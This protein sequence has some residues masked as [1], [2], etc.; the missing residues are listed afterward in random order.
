[1]NGR[2]DEAEANGSDGQPCSTTWPG[3][4]SEA[5]KFRCW[6]P[7]GR[8]GKDPWRGSSPATGS[9]VLIQ[10]TRVKSPSSAGGIGEE[11]TVG[12]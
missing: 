12:E 9:F 2:G 7:T 3:F 10:V 11:E 1:M 5:T 8:A 4:G 6:Q